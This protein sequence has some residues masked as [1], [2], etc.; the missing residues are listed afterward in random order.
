MSTRTDD[1][2]NLNVKLES[3]L[4]KIDKQL[5]ELVLVDNKSG[6]KTEFSTLIDKLS[7][8]VNFTIK[9]AFFL[10]HTVL[11]ELIKSIDNLINIL[12]VDALFIEFKSEDYIPI[13]QENLNKIKDCN[14]N[15]FQKFY[16][17]NVK[18]ENLLN[19]LEI[20][21]NEFSINN[22]DY[23]PKLNEIALKVFSHPLTEDHT[24][25]LIVDTL[26]SAH[27]LYNP[28][29]TP[30][31]DAIKDLYLSL[32]DLDLDLNKVE[33]SKQVQEHTEEY[34]NV[35]K[36]LG[37]QENKDLIYAY[38]IEANQYNS[39]IANYTYVIVF[40]FILIPSSILLNIILYHDSYDWHK[41]V[42]FATFIFSLSAF[43]AFL[44][45]ERSRLV[46]LHTYCMKN[47]LE[48]TALPDYV[49]ELTKEQVQTLRIDL[50]KSYF[51][52]HI[53]NQESLNN[54]KGFSQL[55]TNLDQVVKSISEI[56]NLV[57][58]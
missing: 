20:I 12:P 23:P 40:L 4:L 19:L 14:F 39:N 3:L 11:K 34:K 13:I 55:T 22:V 29:G 33:F 53:D 30:Q 26:L 18:E 50:A 43:L 16:Y 2:K 36:K 27:N 56:K 1:L 38:K 58:K 46:A 32:K 48:L 52:G 47:Y 25:D 42:F 8:E 41:Y 31:A 15:S 7:Y 54:D 49:A 9:A 57:S 37:L 17:E 24:K 6:I 44:I 45:K 51:K 5:D 28:T 10:P 21:E 35:R